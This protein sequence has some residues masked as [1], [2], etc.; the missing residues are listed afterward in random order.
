MVGYTRNLVTAFEH[1]HPNINVYTTGIVM[2]NNAFPEASQNDIIHLI[3][4]AFLAIVVGLFL[5][6]RSVTGTFAALLVI[7]FSIL[8]GMGTAGWLGYKLTPPSASAPTMI[9]TL[10]CCRLCAFFN[11]F[12]KINA[13]RNG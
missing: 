13:R 1:S 2:M 9:L 11:N 3:P 5:F 10:G 4:F 8:L 7:I 6:L 12:F